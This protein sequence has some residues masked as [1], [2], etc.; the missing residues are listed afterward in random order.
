MYEISNRTVLPYSSICYLQCTWPD[1]GPAT[2]ASGIVVGLNDVLTADHAIYDAARG[3]FATSIKVVPGA[4]TSPGLLSPFGSYTDVAVIFA[5]TPDWDNGDAPGLLT[6]DE[7]QF[8]LAVLGLRTPIGNTTG[9]TPVASY[10]NDF[11]GTING[12]PARGSGQM[13]EQIVAH[14][15]ATWQIYDID[16]SLGPGASGGPLLR[17][18]GGVTS[19][20]GVLSSGDGAL[21]ETTYAALYGSNWQWVQDAIHAD[22]AVMQGAQFP[23]AGTF[24]GAATGIVA[25]MGST[26]SETFRSTSLDESFLGRGGSDTVQFSG[27]RTDYRLSH[28]SSDIVVN[29]TVAGRDGRDTLEGPTHVAFSD[30]TVNLQVGADSRAISA[31]DLKLLESLYVGFFNRIPE[32]D[33]LDFWIN[34]VRAGKS[35]VQVADN[36]YSAALQYPAQTGYSAAM[37]NADFVNLVYR[38][39]LGRSEGADPEGLTYWTDALAHGT[40]RGYLVD[41]ILQSALSFKGNATWGWVADLLDNKALVAQHFAVEMGLSYRLPEDSITHGMQMAAAV[42]PTSTAAAVALIGVSDTF[43]TLG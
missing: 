43:S 17:T 33:G 6:P 22:D 16:A 37:T 39:S 29:D 25:Y 42:T 24:P 26:A 35:I 20:V 23:F 19:V 34:Q 5:R 31:W 14:A 18:E 12:Y 27:A 41:Q 38:N 36:F 28:A 3:G 13:E 10:A 30:F 8:D 1:G 11:T 32:A 21:T 9:W 7:S 2:R 4:D 15:S 40:S